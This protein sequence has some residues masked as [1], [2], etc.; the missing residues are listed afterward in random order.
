M[1]RSKPHKTR[2]VA[3][4]RDG[5]RTAARLLLPFDDEAAQ[6]QR[7]QQQRAEGADGAAAN[8]DD[9]DDRALQRRGAFGH[10]LSQGWGLARA[11]MRDGGS[12]WTAAGHESSRVHFGNSSR[13]ACS[14]SCPRRRRSNGGG[15]RQKKIGQIISLVRNFTSKFDGAGKNSAAWSV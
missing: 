1:G 12:C 14:P 8:Y 11:S 10:C 6:A 13:R 2:S 3:V 7:A 5:P 4:Q 15:A 9:V